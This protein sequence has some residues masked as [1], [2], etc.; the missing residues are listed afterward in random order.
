MCFI[1]LTEGCSVNLDDSALY[2][3]IGSDELIV[4]RIVHL[5]E[6]RSWRHPTDVKSATHNTDKSCLSGNMLRSP[7]KVTAIETKSSIFEVSATDTDSVNALGT[8]FGVCRLTTELEL[9]LLAIVGALRTTGGTLVAGCTGNTCV[10]YASMSM[11]W[12]NLKQI[13]ILTHVGRS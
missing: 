8:K 4:R 7:C 9:S 12:E 2:K 10:W 13:A 1:P 11:L 6:R 3:S 5:S